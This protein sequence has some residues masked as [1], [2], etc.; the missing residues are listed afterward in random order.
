[1]PHV[2]APVARRD[3][4]R[5]AVPGQELVYESIQRLWS[6]WAR[7]R[8]RDEFDR[9]ASFALFIGYPRSG[10]SVIGAM[11]NAHRHV[12]I[13][14][15]L[16][17]PRLI[18]EGCDRD[19]LYSRILAR[20][21]W[22][23]LRGN[24]SNYRYQIPNSWQ[25][26][27]ETPLRVVGD[28]GGGWAAQW[29]RKYPDLL[30]RIRGTVGVPLR[31]IHVVRNPY[32]NIAAISQWHQLSLDE[33]IDFYF[34]H[35]ETTASLADAADVRTIRHEA[36]ID[37]PEA[38]LAALCA[39]LDLAPDAGYLAACSSIVFDRPTRSRRRVEWSAAQVAEVERRAR[40]YAFLAGYEFQVADVA[41]RD[42]AARAAAPAGG[43]TS[44]LSRLGAWL[45][46]RV[47]SPSGVGDG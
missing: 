15:E 32:D 35:C 18:I 1:M 27:F 40:R 37:A 6:A 26:R 36:F 20:A 39:F 25:G 4:R 5:N 38:T 14:H 2:Q 13:A 43:A 22:F 16:D 30:Q 9:V 34:S 23:N 10:H 28:K 44:V 7:R 33:S 47:R 42:V 41:E 8:Y 21:A 17:A 19:T 29:L 45:N 46:P 12:V 3:P 24:R 11:L 31:L